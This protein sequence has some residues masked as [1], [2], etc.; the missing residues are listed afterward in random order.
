[1]WTVFP[2]CLNNF[3]ADCGLMKPT[4]QL[5]HSVVCKSVDFCHHEVPNMTAMIGSCCSQSRRSLNLR[6]TLQLY[7]KIRATLHFT[8]EIKSIFTH[9]K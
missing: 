4:K 1:M 6:L 9:D 3:V 8:L 5:F 2:L 7:I